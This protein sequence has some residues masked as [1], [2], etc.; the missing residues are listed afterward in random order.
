M[1]EVI[2]IKNT[3]LDE[4]YGLVRLGKYKDINEAFNRAIELLLEREA[5]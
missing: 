3:K 1:D 5:I 2:A 4:I